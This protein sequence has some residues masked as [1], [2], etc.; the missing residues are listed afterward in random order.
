VLGSGIFGFIVGRRLAFSATPR[1]RS[2]FPLMFMHVFPSG[3]ESMESMAMLALLAIG[4]FAGNVF[5]VGIALAL[6]A[7]LHR[8]HERKPDKDIAF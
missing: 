3:F 1:R 8:P 4:V 2:P 6:V 7:L 5:L